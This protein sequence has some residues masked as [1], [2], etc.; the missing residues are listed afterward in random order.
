[1]N[2]SDGYRVDYTAAGTGFAYVADMSNAAAA[3]GALGISGGGRAATQD[4]AFITDNC[5]S[6]A[7]ALA[8]DKT[9]VGATGSNL[10]MTNTVVAAPASNLGRIVTASYNA[11]AAGAV[12]SVALFRSHTATWAASGGNKR[13]VVHIEATHA[14][15]TAADD[16]ALRIN[17]TTTNIVALHVDAGTCQFDEAILVGVNSSG[18]GADS[19]FE[20]GAAERLRVDAGTV[21]H[22]ATGGAIDLNLTT[23]TAAVV[24]IDA[25]LTLSADV[26]N[27]ASIRSHLNTSAMGGGA[28]VSGT[29][30]SAAY[31]ADVTGN[32]DAAETGTLAAYEARSP[33]TVHAN[34]TV[35]GLLVGTG[36]TDCL[37]AES[38]NLSF[39]DHAGVIR[40]VNSAGAASGLTV[41]SADGVGAGNAGG[42]LVFVVAKGGTNT[43]DDG[44]FIVRLDDQAS[45]GSGDEARFVLE[46]DD[47]TTRFFELDLGRTGTDPSNKSTQSGLSVDGVA[48]PFKTILLPLREAFDE[49]NGVTATV[50]VVDGAG[51]LSYSYINVPNAGLDLT[52]NFPIPDDFDPNSDVIVTVYGVMDGAGS[53]NSLDLDC[54]IKAIA[55]NEAFAGATTPD[56]SG[57]TSGEGAVSI[58]TTVS[59][60]DNDLVISRGTIT[61]GASAG[62]LTAN[63]NEN[64]HFRLVRS[65]DTYT[66]ALQLTKVKLTYRSDRV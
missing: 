29:K 31:S 52:W 45:G 27:T 21:V 42:N 62:Q 58:A 28:G 46:N 48:R 7:D 66:G 39:I 63:A 4:I 24:G 16:A 64:G 22:T 51:N 12:G 8:I 56:V 30:I 37:R 5:T 55:D 17:A 36:Y 53:G 15:G 57:A 50:A 18:M 11:A 34:T 61:G 35:P 41:R 23:S 59:H 38:G 6:T 13:S 43:G 14:G 9:G 19:V 3:A 32:N 47:S 65:T 60:A 49:T 54:G 2:A 44:D 25:A 10:H 26:D 1:V 33:A 40:E 20:L